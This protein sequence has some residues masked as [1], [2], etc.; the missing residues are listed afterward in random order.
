MNWLD[1]CLIF[2]MLANLISSVAKG[3]SREVI[4]LVATVAGLL[5]ALW[6]YGSA[7]A[8]LIP[9]VSSKGVANFCGFLIVFFGIILLGA[10]TGKLLAKL[11]KWTGL[12]LVDRLLGGA[13]GL[14]KGTA[15]GVAMILVISAFMPAREPGKP[16]A[17]VA[18]SRIAPYVMGVAHAVS[19]IAPYEL[20]EGFHRTYEQLQNIWHGTVKGGARVLPGSEM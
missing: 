2:I 3:F 11:L 4:S 6:F 10:V 15:I 17:A 8:F 1:Y 9:Y 14:L 5:C 13:F 12:S 7:G 16:P 19:R 20:R 18:E